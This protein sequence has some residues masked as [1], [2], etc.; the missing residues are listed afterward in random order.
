MVSTLGD[1]MRMVLGL[2][3]IALVVC[4][5]AS[6]IYLVRHYMGIARAPKTCVCALVVRQCMLR[7]SFWTAFQCEDGLEREFVVS[8][9]EY[10]ELA[11][12]D[13]G[14]LCYQGLRFLS[15]QQLQPSLPRQVP[16]EG[17]E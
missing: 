12:G 1:V 4:G 5:V 7:G 10:M 13:E 11:E 9:D 3:A 6:I 15:F 16:P 17:R 8:Q 14:L 2:A